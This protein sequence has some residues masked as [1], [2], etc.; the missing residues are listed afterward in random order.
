MMIM[1]TT[2]FLGVVALKVERALLPG[3]QTLTS[4][5]DGALSNESEV[6]G[7]DLILKRSVTVLRC[8]VTL[9]EL[10]QLD[11]RT[12]FRLHPFTLFC[13][14]QANNL[15]E[16]SRLVFGCRFSRIRRCVI[17]DRG[18]VKHRTSNVDHQVR[19]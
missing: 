12:N 1:Y 3:H 13:R 8:L 10:L 14:S 11:E 15:V 18:T 6:L 5:T 2:R 7:E 17:S 19:C 4:F 9:G 16:F